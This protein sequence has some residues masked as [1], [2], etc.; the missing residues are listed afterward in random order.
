MPFLQDYFAIKN[1]IEN[2]HI[3]EDTVVLPGHPGDFL[4]GSHLYHSLKNDSS[5]QV[6]ISLFQAFGTS[7]P[8]SATQKEL[9]FETIEKQIFNQQSGTCN[10]FDRWDYEE[11]QCKF[12]GNSSQ[13]YS[14]FNIPYLMPL[15]DKDIFSTMLSL[16]FRQRLYATLYNNTLETIL[17]RE[18]GID[19]DLK[20]KETGFKKPSWLKEFLIRVAPISVRKKY[21]PADDNV[22]YKEITSLLMSSYPITNYKQPVKPNLYNGY[23]IQWYIT[24]LESRFTNG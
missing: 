5:Y 6:A 13:L 18:N 10:N 11:R 7:L 12:I 15:F 23:L 8:L 24:W 16:P 17:F 2:G 19:F 9:V 22:F 20:T 1:L 4:R 3:N 21:Y 14:F